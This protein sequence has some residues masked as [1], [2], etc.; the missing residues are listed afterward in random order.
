ML[1]KPLFLLIQHILDWWSNKLWQEYSKQLTFWILIFC[2]VGI[3][4]VLIGWYLGFPR[5]VEMLAI[6][7]WVASITVI[8]YSNKARD[9]NLEKIK[10]NG[11]LSKEELSMII[12]LKESD[13]PALTDIL[14][15]VISSNSNVDIGG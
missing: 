9:E 3:V 11:V 2:G 8:Y 5:A 13:S 10:K 15:K 7:A 14:S 4:A 6:F 12:K 1:V